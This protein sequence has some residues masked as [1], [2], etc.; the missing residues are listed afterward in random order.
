M[1]IFSVLLVSLILSPSLAADTKPDKQSSWPKTKIGDLAR[2]WV[3]SF[4]SGDEAMRKYFIHDM[5][6]GDDPAK[7]DERM[8]SYRAGRQH[9]GS[10]KF[11][12]I[13]SAT[14][15]ELVAV[16][17]L[18]N[19]TPVNATFTAQAQPP[20]KLV[21]VKFEMQRGEDQ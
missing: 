4:S 15:T 13:V 5:V 3:E 1:R 9:L 17:T 7:V 19:G 6:N 10:L 14:S 12:S 8:S 21:S 2:R 20:F 11:S 16:M 18:A